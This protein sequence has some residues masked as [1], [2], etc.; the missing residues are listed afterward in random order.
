MLNRDFLLKLDLSLNDLQ[1]K[2]L[3]EYAELVLSKNKEFNLTAA[4]TIQE[5]FDRHICDGL[6][7][8]SYLK[9]KGLTKHIGADFGSG[10]GF[11]GIA[12]A[13]AL[14]ENT[15]YLVDS[16]QK[17]INFLQWVIY[18]LGL[19]NLK[20]SNI[21]IGKE[22][23]HLRF[24]FVMERAMGEIDDILPLCLDALNDQGAFLALLSKNTKSAQIA[25]EEYSYS[26]PGDKEILGRKIAVYYG[27]K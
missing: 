8:A 18:K 10:A 4:K 5:I 22:R 24:D 12:V 19:K 6:Q 16:L 11:I 1:I 15:I 27:H 21:K 20:I 25:G 26:L 7:M 2:T 23:L 14:P 3:Q 9:R 13:V 17:R